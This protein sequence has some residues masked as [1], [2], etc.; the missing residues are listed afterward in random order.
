M[1]VVALLFLNLLLPPAI[2]QTSVAGAWEVRAD[3]ASRK[4]DDGGSVSRSAQQF[5]LDLKV[6][7]SKAS[8]TLTPKAG[9]GSP[10]TLGGSWERDKLELASAWRDLQGTNNGKPTTLRARYIVRLTLANAALAGTCEL[11]IENGEA[12]PQPCTAKRAK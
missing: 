2:S 8:A 5:R 11:A 3:A 10:W 1:T 7:G 6:D 9:P 4:T 12:M